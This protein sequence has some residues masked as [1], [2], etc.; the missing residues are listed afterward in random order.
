MTQRT[1]AT[2]GTALAITFIAGAGGSA[3]LHNSI[4]VCAVG[5]AV[6]FGLGFLV[7]RPAVRR[8]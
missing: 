2:L 5:S 8:I 4:V 6:G 7:Q 1:S 3:G